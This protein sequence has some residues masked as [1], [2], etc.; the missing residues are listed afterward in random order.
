MP[1][2][3]DALRSPDLQEAVVS[4]VHDILACHVPEESPD[5]AKHGFV[6]A[7]RIILKALLDP[8][9]LG[10]G[11]DAA[12]KRRCVMTL[13]AIT[14]ELLQRAKHCQ[15]QEVDGASLEALL[16]TYARL[17]VHSLEVSS[18]LHEGLLQCL[19]QLANDEAGRA[20]LLPRARELAELCAS[21]LLQTPSAQPLY[22]RQAKA[23][24]AI[25]ESPQR[26]HR[27]RE[28]TREL[29][30]VCC[31]L[32]QRLAQELLVEAGA[33]EGEEAA[34]ETSEER[35][36]EP[37]REQVLTSLHRDNL[38]LHRLTRGHEPLRR[39][40]AAARQ[41]WEAEVG[42]E[43]ARPPPK[44]RHRGMK[45]ALAMRELL[46]EQ[47]QKKRPG[48][49][50]PRKP[51]K[52]WKDADGA[53]QGC[54]GASGAAGAAGTS[55]ARTRAA[56]AARAARWHCLSRQRW[57]VQHRCSR[58][59]SSRGRTGLRRG[60]V[61]QSCQRGACITHADDASLTAR[62]GCEA[63][64][65]ITV[66]HVNILALR[67]CS[68]ADLRCGAASGGSDDGCWTCPQDAAAVGGWAHVSTEGFEIKRSAQR[69]KK[70]CTSQD[71]QRRRHRGDS[72]CLDGR[73]GF[74][75]RGVSKVT[76]SGA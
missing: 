45:S 46:E 57:R 1:L 27:A 73:A 8:L 74:H 17:L 24:L 29:A 13:A 22:V 16:E 61:L 44:P 43:V 63:A 65:S 12:V 50:Q 69:S 75:A 36:L 34:K 10:M 32:L 51:A 2:L 52:G 48:R 59:R 70:R 41:A 39:A 19:V 72:R 60:I 30:M 64:K 38:N 56:R 5:A 21:H 15:P 42:A 66:D 76:Q 35:S 58:W 31:L 7:G 18:E 25:S 54:S 40:I 23:E 37:L 9:A 68:D 62:G 26:T 33:A 14:K 53:V 47:E 67:G 4:T 49:S 11:W 6:Q 28:L 71:G 55:G 3:V 20:G